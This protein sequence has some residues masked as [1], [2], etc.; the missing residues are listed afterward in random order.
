[1]QAGQSEDPAWATSQKELTAALQNPDAAYEE[2]KA[3]FRP[4]A[5]GQR[6]LQ[7]TQQTAEALEINA[8]RKAAFLANAAFSAA[9]NAK[10]TNTC[11]TAAAK[12]PFAAALRPFQSDPARYAPTVGVLS[13]SLP[14]F[15]VAVSS[16][17]HHF[18]NVACGCWVIA[19]SNGFAS[20]IFR[21]KLRA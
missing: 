15:T 14:S 9:E 13:C 4:A 12:G 17:Q 19:R 5:A 11:V 8:R 16:A 7:G 6:R 3:K 1:M 21:A 10:G 18:S 2:F 20:A